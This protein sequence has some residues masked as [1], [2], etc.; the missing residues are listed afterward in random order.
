MNR[1]FTYSQNVEE[2]D[3]S[4]R[5]IS[6]EIDDAAFKIPDIG[7]FEATQLIPRCIA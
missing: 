4:H 7:L 5:L 6:N 1:I 2:A 3:T